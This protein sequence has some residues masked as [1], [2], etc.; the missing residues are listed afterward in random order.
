MQLHL[1]VDKEMEEIMGKIKNVLQALKKW[2]FLED[3]EEEFSSEQPRYELK[4]QF[5]VP[6]EKAEAAIRVMMGDLRE[7]LDY[8]FDGAEVDEIIYDEEDDAKV[9]DFPQSTEITKKAR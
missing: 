2:I 8:A 1:T 6:A 9:I 5:D 4:L 7:V 3:E